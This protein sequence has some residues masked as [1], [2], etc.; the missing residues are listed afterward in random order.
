MSANI[1]AASCLSKCSPIETALS[2]A[3]E[4]CS[5]AAH[6]EILVMTEDQYR[7]RAVLMRRRRPLNR[8]RGFPNGRSSVAGKG[9]RYPHLAAQDELHRA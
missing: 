5:G 2:H 8:L 7:R 4:A 9:G 1:A 6:V 3:G